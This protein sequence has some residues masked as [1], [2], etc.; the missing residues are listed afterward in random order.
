MWITLR[1]LLR[2]LAL[3]GLLLTWLL[4]PAAAVE[5]QRV[6]ETA[7]SVGMGV[8]YATGDFG[9]DTDTDFVTVPFSVTVAPNQ[10]FAMEL[11]IPFVYQSNSSNVYG[12][13]MPYRSSSGNSRAKAGGNRFISGPGGQTNGTGG[14]SFNPDDSESGIGDLSLTGDYRF[15]QQGDW[16]ELRATLY[17][18]FPTADED[19]GL[20]TGEFDFGPGLAASSWFDD[21]HLRL[22]GSYIFQ[23]DSDLYATKDYLSYN[24]GVGYQFTRSFYSALML[25]GATAPAEDSPEL[26]EGRVKFSW[27][28]AEKMALE[29]Y[30]AKGLSDGSPDVGAGVSIYYDF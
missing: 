26:L 21:W 5:R 30:G 9:S 1:A 11:V 23:G 29:G 24:G 15:L 19:K 27:R 25:Y 16:P 18:K 2:S 4:E 22:E 14:S 6:K 17:L 7:V 12:A 28:F 8:E 20:G 10:D 3:S 13:T